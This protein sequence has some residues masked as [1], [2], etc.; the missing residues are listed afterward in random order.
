MTRSNGVDDRRVD[1]GFTLVELLIVIVIVGLTVGV[2]SSAII[3]V[4]RNEVATSQR[5]DDNRDLLQLASWLPADVN[6]T[7]VGTVPGTGVEPGSTLF[8][9]LV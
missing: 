8:H 6:S 1:S 3:V 5:L 7:P 4:L 2:L 9:Y